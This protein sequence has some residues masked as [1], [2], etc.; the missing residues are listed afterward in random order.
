MKQ[1]GKQIITAIVSIPMSKQHKT[2]LGG[3]AQTVV[4]ETKSGDEPCGTCEYGAKHG[5]WG[6]QT[7]APNHCGDCHRFWRSANEGH[8]AQCCQHFTN[9]AAF[10]AH[11]DNDSCLDPAT[12]TRMDGRPRLVCRESAFGP[13]WALVNYRPKPDFAALRKQ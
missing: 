8:C 10:D 3:A 1:L 4:K 6:Q 7:P 2:Q 9:T 12:V 11:I 5:W 13:I